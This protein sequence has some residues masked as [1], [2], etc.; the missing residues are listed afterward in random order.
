MSTT[1]HN[2][3]E[4]SQNVLSYQLNNRSKFKPANEPVLAAVDNA[5]LPNNNYESEYMQSDAM[6]LHNSPSPKEIQLIACPYNCA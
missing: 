5:V 3:N 1:C 4:S 6:Y 2:H